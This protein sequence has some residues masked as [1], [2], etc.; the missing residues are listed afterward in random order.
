VRR[1]CTPPACTLARNASKRPEA[2]G[3][4]KAASSGSEDL[5][6]HASNAAQ[7]VLR[8]CTCRTMA[9]ARRQHSFAAG[10]LHTCDRQFLMLPVSLVS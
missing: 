2:I 6:A 7:S 8:A 1:I 10:Q 3:V 5:T 9:F 4:S